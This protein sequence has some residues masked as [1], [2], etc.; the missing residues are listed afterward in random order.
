[1]CIL[2]YIGQIK[3]RWWYGITQCYLPPGRDDIPNPAFTPRSKA[4]TR[5]SDTGWMQRWVGLVGWLHTMMVYSRPHGSYSV[6]PHLSIYW[7]LKV[8]PHLEYVATLLCETLVSAK[9]AINN[10][11][12]GNVATY[13]RRGGVVNNRIKKGLLLSLWVKKNWNR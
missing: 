13:L 10:K 3:W 12:H 9:Q 2:L 8:P 6:H 5:F 1:M 11:L 4:G 7:I